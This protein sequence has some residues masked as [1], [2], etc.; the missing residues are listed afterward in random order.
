MISKGGQLFL[1]LLLKGI[2]E[3][4][5]ISL[6]QARSSVLLDVSLDLRLPATPLIEETLDSFNILVVFLISEVLKTEGLLKLM[7]LAALLEL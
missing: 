4:P 3:L 1:N 2:T 5:A 7:D 6:H